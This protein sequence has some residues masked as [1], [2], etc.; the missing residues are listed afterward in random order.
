MQSRNFSGTRCHGISGEWAER[1]VAG[2]VL[3]V[4]M[5]LVGGLLAFAA[6]SAMADEVLVC[7]SAQENIEFDHDD[8]I[9]EWVDINHRLW[10]AQI[11]TTTGKFIPSTGM[12][13]L[14]DTNVTYAGTFGNGPEFVH[15]TSGYSIV[16][17]KFIPPAKPNSLNPATT[18]IA[19]A[20]L[21]GS[22]WSVTNDVNSSWRSSLLGYLEPEG[23]QNP[24]QSDPPF[25]FHDGVDTASP[26]YV[27]GIHDFQPTVVPGSNSDQTFG[28]A[29]FVPGLNELLY[30]APVTVNGQTARQAF[31]YDVTTGVTTQLTFDA[32]NKGNVFM[33][34]SPE[35]NNAYVLML[36]INRK[37]LSFYTYQYNRTT[38]KSSWTLVNSIYP[39]QGALAP[40][41]VISPEAFFYKNKTYVYMIRSQSANS[42]TLSVPTEV[43][44]ASMDGSYYARVSG[45]ATASPAVRNDPKYY[46][47]STGIYIYY[48]KYSL[49]DPQNGIK[50]QALGT[51]KS[52]SGIPL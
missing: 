7:T 34:Q 12:G 48:V 2:T 21:S 46:I 25:V 13:T 31:S 15:S 44:V 20:D 40:P 42:E 47:T 29:R 30:T 27:M 45:S 51:W 9:L 1:P 33:F 43:W 49:A 23:N 14:V 16:Y 32:T 28:S 24:T 11:D 10:T 36:S 38:H 35:Y 19:R 6:G 41:F 5:P 52:N 4:L 3:R 8:G 17:N 39:P 26:L 22:T 18:Y 50:A 37:Y